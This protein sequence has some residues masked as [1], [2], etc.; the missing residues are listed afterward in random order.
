MAQETPT[1]EAVQ[2]S[3]ARMRGVMASRVVLQDGVISEV[4]ILA[5]ADRPAKQIVRDVESLCAAEFGIRIDHR[6]VSVALIEAPERPTKTRRRP[7]IRGVRI[8]REGGHFS[9]HVSLAV[10]DELCQGS[11]EGPN[12]NQYRLAATATL[13]ALEESLRGSCRLV[14]DDLVPFHLGSWNGYLVGVVMLSTFG[15][16]RLVGSALVKKDAVDA[17]IR[18]ACDAVNRRIGVVGLSNLQSL[19]R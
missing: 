10:G 18:A 7:V 15:E 1:A 4:H 11:A 8:E 13:R 14:L 19:G 9:V 6:K 5:E 17:V 12:V 3:I 2:S 16:E